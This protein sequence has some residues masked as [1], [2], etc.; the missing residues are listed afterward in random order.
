MI[1]RLKWHERL[2]CWLLFK[3]E[4]KHGFGGGFDELN[5][6]AMKWLIKDDHMIYCAVFSLMR[7]YIYIRMAREHEKEKGA[8]K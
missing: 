8:S 6:E 4:A 2:L 3:I 1:P 5:M 7:D